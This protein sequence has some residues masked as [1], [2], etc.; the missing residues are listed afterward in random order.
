M[1]LSDDQLAQYERDGFLRVERL[2][3]GDDLDALRAAYD[4]LLATSADGRML[5][6]VTRQIMNPS[7]L[8]PAFNRNAAVGAAKEIASQVLDAPVRRLFDMLIFKPPQH[9]H[10]TPWHQ[11]ASYV[12]QPFSPPGS[13]HRLSTLQFWVALD[14]ADEENGCMHFVPGVHVE[15]LLEHEV[16]AGDPNE[17]SR[18]LAIVGAADVLDL[19]AAVAAPVPAGGCTF[20][21]ERTPHFTPPNR[22]ADRPRRAYIFNLVRT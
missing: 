7:A 1:R 20:H 11:D 8:H 16:A 5:G 9:A 22:S 13:R 18:L 4:E 6:G 15:P 3:H 2:V 12:D 10:A 14:D 19:D 17:D 21:N